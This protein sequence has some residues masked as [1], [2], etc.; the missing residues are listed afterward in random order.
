MAGMDWTDPNAAI[1]YV[2]MDRI[3]WMRDDAEVER[4]KKEIEALR[5][6]NYKLRMCAWSRR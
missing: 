4:L 5:R 3:V 1:K 6:E 2:Y